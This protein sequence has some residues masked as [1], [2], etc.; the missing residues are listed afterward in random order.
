MVELVLR[1][2]RAY[3]QL[4]LLGVIQGHKFIPKYHRG[5][6]KFLF[7]QVDDI[8]IYKK[9]TKLMRK[10]FDMRQDGSLTR[11]DFET[12]IHENGQFIIL[13]DG[14]VEQDIINLR[15]WR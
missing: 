6:L 4:R 9:P 12:Y 2:A 15:R 8:Y 11:I 13:D 14:S 10:F 5:F 3:E 1:S 7:E